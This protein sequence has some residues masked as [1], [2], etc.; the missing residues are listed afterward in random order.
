MTNK[1]T[2]IIAIVLMAIPSLMLVMSGVMKLM[3]SPQIVDSLGKIGLGSYITLLG[4]IEILAVALFIYPKTS[5]I[6]FLLLCCYLGGALSIELASGH[7][8]MAAAFLTLLW[9]SVFL[10]NKAMFLAP[11]TGEVSK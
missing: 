5:R 9:V 8:P 2:R 4:I 11:A 10:S 7:P 3:A 1:T 6:G